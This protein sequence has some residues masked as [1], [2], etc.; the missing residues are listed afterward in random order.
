MAQY[1]KKYKTTADIK[2]GEGW[3][4]IG[5]SMATRWGDAAAMRNVILHPEMENDLHA[6]L[7]LHV[8]LSELLSSSRERESS[9]VTWPLMPAF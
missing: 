5:P 9:I 4:N 2:K 6:R 7:Y 1:Q 3:A 8:T